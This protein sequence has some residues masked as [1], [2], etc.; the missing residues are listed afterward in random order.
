MQVAID[1][2]LLLHAQQA[3]GLTSDRELLEYG[4][5]LAI[6]ARAFKPSRSPLLARGNVGRACEHLGESRIEP[7]DTPSVYQGPPL[8]L[9]AMEAAIMAEAARHR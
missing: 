6:A 5:R 8:S 4:L 1:E 3:T 9:A 7:P 2:Q